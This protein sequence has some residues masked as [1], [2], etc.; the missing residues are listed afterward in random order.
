[1]QAAETRTKTAELMKRNLLLPATFV[2]NWR[3][4][5]GVSGVRQ[6]LLLSVSHVRTDG[7]QPL[8]VLRT[9]SICPQLKYPARGTKKYLVVR[10]VEKRVPQQDRCSPDPWYFRL[11]YPQ[12]KRFL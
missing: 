7:T 9:S 6:R 11:I 5:D 12:T 3:F 10:I 2:D 1:M 8:A 4:Y